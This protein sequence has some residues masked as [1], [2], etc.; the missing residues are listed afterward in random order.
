[1]PANRSR[2]LQWRRC[3]E[4]IYQRN[5]AIEIAIARAYD[6]NEDGRHLVWRVRV[7]KLTESEVIVEQPT[8]L[9]QPIPLNQGVA[10]IAIMA[11]GQNRWMF[12][13]TNLGLTR[14]ALNAQKSIPAVRLLMPDSVMRCQR[15]NYYRVE[16]AALNLPEV[17]IWPLLDPKSVVVAERA[18]E[19]LFEQDRR[20]DEASA[21]PE[22]F[23]LSDDSIMPEVGPRFS[24]TLLN[25]GGGGVGLHVPPEHSQVLFR[26]KLFWTRFSL[27]PELSVPICASAK[28]IHTHRESSQ[29]I[30]AG[31]AFDFTFNA[32]HQR[33]VV[34]Q[35]CRY[36]A[37]QQ[38]MQLQRQ[39]HD[40]QQRRIA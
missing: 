36:I 14:F 17:E 7:L 30:Y 24:A 11:V 8:A 4:Q 23:S 18:N 16:T 9:G 34:D 1:M 37:V 32:G 13:T 29:H 21:G 38:R 19:L 40:E 20:S 6:E 15:R 26:H 5:G 10:L 12:N 2:T 31:L 3:L 22:P 28:L 25:I 33:F 27:P 35:I 39:V